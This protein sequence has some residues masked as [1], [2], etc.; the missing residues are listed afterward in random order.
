VGALARTALAG[1]RFAAVKWVLSTAVQLYSC[2]SVYKMDPWIPGIE[3]H[4]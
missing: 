3:A 1:C 4:L 2:I